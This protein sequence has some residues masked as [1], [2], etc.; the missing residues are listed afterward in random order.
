M[1]GAASTRIL[2]TGRGVPSKVLTNQDLSRMVD[3]SDEWIVE[4]TGIRERHI[5]EAPLAASD[6]AAEAGRNACAAAGVPTSEVDCIIVGTVTG[7]CPFPS[8][9]VF[10]QKKLGALAGGCAFDLSAACAGFIYGLSLGDNFVLRGQFRRVLVIG[11]AVLSRIVDWQDR[12]TCV[13]FGDGAG[14]VLLGPE[15][16]PKRGVLSTHLY[17]DGSFT[18]VLL[19]QAGGSREPIT[20][21]AIAA[22]RHLVKMN[23]REVYKHAVRNMAASARTALEANGLTPADVA[24][25]IGH[26]ANLRILE[27]VSE[28]VGIPMDRFFL[29]VDRYGNTSSASVPTALDE[30]IE[31]KKLREGDILV[32]TALGGG[33]A[34]ASAAVRW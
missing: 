9:A 11:V 22:K 29:N 3:T 34:W 15:S 7:D 6:L 30:A 14:A 16:D 21:E 23:G 8:T 32:F 18:E 27:G 4:R 13:L 12:S 5:L 24:W 19:Q 31:Q 10:V 17:S 1:I 20:A 28:R 33:L 25:V 2:G 26:Q